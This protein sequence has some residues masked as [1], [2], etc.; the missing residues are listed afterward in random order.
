ML[1]KKFS[2]L[3]PPGIDQFEVESAARNPR[4]P[5]TEALLRAQ[6]PNRFHDCFHD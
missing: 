4:R 6:H 2:E 1:Y 3:P 5:A